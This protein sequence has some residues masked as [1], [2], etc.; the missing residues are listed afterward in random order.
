MKDWDSEWNEPMF[1]S[2]PIECPSDEEKVYYVWIYED[3]TT[4]PTPRDRF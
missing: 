1:Y 2:H 3:F 4:Y